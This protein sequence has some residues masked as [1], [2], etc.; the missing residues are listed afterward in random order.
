MKC[1]VEIDSGVMLHIS[2]FIMIGSPIQKLIRGDTYTHRRMV[3]A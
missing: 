3:I 1:A 2:S